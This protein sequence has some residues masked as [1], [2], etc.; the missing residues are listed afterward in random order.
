MRAVCMLP[1][2]HGRMH[3]HIGRRL[4]PRK[5]TR[6][7]ISLRNDPLSLRIIVNESHF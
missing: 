5:E 3:V 7:I 6:T 1:S 4:T 2:D